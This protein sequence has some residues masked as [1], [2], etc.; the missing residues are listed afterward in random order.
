MSYIDGIVAPVRAGMDAEAY[1]A[2]AASVAAIFRDHGATRV[3]DAWADDVPRGQHTDFHRAV[4]AEPGE[5][6]VFSWIEWPDKATR[7]AAMPKVTADPRMQAGAMSI[8]VD[9]KRMILGGF[10]TLL[11]V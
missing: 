10:H 7:D 11:D 8:P 2:F 4:A 1:R 3:V 6:V 9:G 5:T